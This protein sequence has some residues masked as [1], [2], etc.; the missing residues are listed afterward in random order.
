MLDKAKGIVKQQAKQFAKKLAKKAILKLL[1]FLA[2]YALPILAVLLVM[3]VIGVL[4]AGTYSTMAPGGYMTGINPSPEDEVIQARYASLAET[5]WDGEP[6]WNAN[7]CYFVEEESFG[8]EQYYPKTNFE[9]LHAL[10][11]KYRQDFDMRLRWGTIHAIGLFWAYNYGKDKIPDDMPDKIAEDLHPHFYYI[12]RTESISVSCPDGG[13]SDSWDVYLLVEAHT[14]YGF[15]QYHYESVTET[16]TSG[17]CTITTT[18]WQLKD[19]KQLWPDRW[20]WI[21]KYLKDMYSIDRDVQQETEMARAW[22]MEAGEGFTQKKE[23]LEWLLSNYTIEAI[24]SGAMI[25]PEYLP[26]L[27]EAE[28]KF[29]IPW[30]FLAALIQKESSWDFMAV[31]KDSGCFGL[32]QQHPDYWEERWQRLGFDPPEEYQWNPRAQILAGAMVLADYIGGSVDWEDGWKTDPQVLKG[33]AKYGGYGDNVGAAQGYISDIIAYAEGMAVE[34]VWPVPGHYVITCFF[35]EKDELHPNGHKGID[36]ALEDGTPV[37]SVSAGTVTFVGWDPDGYGYY[38]TIRD[39]NH[40]Y[41]YAHLQADSALVRM[42]DTVAP[43]QTIALGDSTGRST[44]PH[45]HFGVKDL[46]N[47]RW[48]DPLMVVQ[49]H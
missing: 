47:G 6:A 16:H 45:L 21:K 42:N 35:N 36:I 2:P 39:A 49:P 28:E 11:D 13:Y 8:K 22:V 7:D 38:I 33:L 26:M 46:A 1:V 24:T 25:P 15:Y 9:N 23:W 44:G 12:K 3:G 32:T 48:I 29:G 34:A 27:R 41:Y 40:L 17:E 30:W 4:I 14:V 20:Q 19:K 37:V 31:N 18:T 43:G 10:M 5:V